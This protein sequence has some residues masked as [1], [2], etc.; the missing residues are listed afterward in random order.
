[1]IG[2]L[3]PIYRMPLYFFDEQ[4]RRTLEEAKRR[5]AE[6]GSISARAAEINAK[7]TLDLYKRVCLN[8]FKGNLTFL[9]VIFKY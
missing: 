7:F 6:S 5:K 2:Q 9:E 1:M 4:L 3:E 8:V